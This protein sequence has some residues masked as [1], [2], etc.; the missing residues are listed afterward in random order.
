MTRHFLGLFKTSFVAILASLFFATILYAAPPKP[1]KNIPPPPKKIPTLKVQ[2]LKLPTNHFD[3]AQVGTNKLI[4][5]KIA[6]LQ[7][8]QQ[9]YLKKINKLEENV[10]KIKN[11]LFVEAD[12]PRNNKKQKKSHRKRLKQFKKNLSQL[13]KQIK[14]FRKKEEIFQKK[15]AQLEGKLIQSGPPVPPDPS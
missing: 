12:A 7:K 15:I 14:Q 4:R 13:K 10:H 1:P 3:K 6:F 9:I 5:K 8:Q 2:K 11:L